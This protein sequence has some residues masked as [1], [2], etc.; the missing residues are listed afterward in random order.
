MNSPRV[1]DGS[2]V[3]ARADYR[4]KLHQLGKI[5]HALHARRHQQV[6]PRAMVAIVGSALVYLGINSISRLGVST[7]LSPAH[8]SIAAWIGAAVAWGLVMRFGKVPRSYTDQLDGLLERYD[9]VSREAYRELQQQ[10]K[11]HGLETDLVLTWLLEERAAIE[12]AAGRQAPHE[13][14]FLRKKV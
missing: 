2:A 1:V 6:G 14:R 13:R 7:H 4:Q 11:E 5:R 8:L 9:P 12:Q 10:V 3:I